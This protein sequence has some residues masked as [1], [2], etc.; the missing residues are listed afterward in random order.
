MEA[1]G[2]IAK[3]DLV[4]GA[5]YWGFCRNAQEAVWHADKPSRAGYERQDKVLGCFTYQRTKWG[6][7]YD[8]DINHPEDDDGFDLFV[9]VARKEEEETSNA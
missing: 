9:P 4:D 3:R 2:M 6:S 1:A 7:T 5:A 8:E